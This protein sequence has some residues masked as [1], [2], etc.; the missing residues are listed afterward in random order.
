MSL[1][2]RNI[3]KKYLSTFLI[4][5]KN[6]ISTLIVDEIGKKIISN[7]L[8]MTDLIEYNIHF[9]ELLDNDRYDNKYN[10]IYFIHPNEKNITQI[11]KDFDD[12][13]PLY[14]TESNVNIYSTT[15]IKNELFDKFKNIKNLLKRLKKLVE[16][17]CNFITRSETFIDLNF[18]NTN[19]LLIFDNNNYEEIILQIKN[20]CDITN[21][22]PQIRFQKKSHKNICDDITIGLNKMIVYNKYKIITPTLI[23]DRT[24]DLATP[25]LHGITYQSCMD[26]FDIQYNNNNMLI[27]GDYFWIHNKNKHL[28][29]VS[30]N[31]NN[32]INELKN[33]NVEKMK[34][35]KDISSMIS[36][37]RD[38]SNYKNKSLI[39]KNHTTLL[40]KC[41]KEITNINK[42]IDYEYELVMCCDENYNYLTNNILAEK[43]HNILINNDISN[44]LK[45]RI[46]SLF[47]ITQKK[48]ND[49]V[50]YEKIKSY[51]VT[52]ENKLNKLTKYNNSID[53]SSPKKPDYLSAKSLYNKFIELTN[54]INMTD[55]ESLKIQIMKNKDNNLIKHSGYIPTIEEY[56]I[57]LLDGTLSD[58]QLTQP[59]KLI[60]TSNFL[61]NNN[62]KTNIDALVIILGGVTSCELA[63]VK[64]L[65]DKRNKNIV[66][67]SN[68]IIKHENI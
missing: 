12:D 55:K 4:V 56:I 50:L 6:T 33:S 37:V 13:K 51:L 2:M 45:E 35:N 21:I 64:K 68:G 26:S 8:T 43:L 61:V 23:Y 54:I 22:Y 19:P 40:D 18:D 25:L 53:L 36:V 60:N 9:V 11:C 67:I 15:K 58:E 63:E 29:E 39:I 49:P 41:M 57:N 48:I 16:L 31:L 14:K 47:F 5:H 34:S 52:H 1:S 28:V 62:T 65:C 24:I 27:D 3:L 17:N 44:N 32:L 66:F 30:N 10:K 7:C 38:L 20:F 59:V 42:I 46:I